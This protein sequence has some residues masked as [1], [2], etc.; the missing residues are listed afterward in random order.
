MAEFQQ[1]A[2]QVLRNGQHFADCHSA[3]DAAAIVAAMN[4]PNDGKAL[5]KHISPQLREAHREGI[6]DVIGEIT[7]HLDAEIAKRPRARAFTQGITFA[8]NEILGRMWEADEPAPEGV[9]ATYNELN[10]PP[11]VECV[12]TV[13]EGGRRG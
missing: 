6:T 7:A 10:A 8:R 11:A 4:L 3:D 2:Q 13:Q 9:R 1:N 5:L 12:P